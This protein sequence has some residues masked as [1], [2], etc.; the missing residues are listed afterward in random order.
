MNLGAVILCRYDSSR[1]PGK[2]L[3][4]IEGREILGYIVDR[5]RQ[6]FES[7]NIVVATSTEASDDPIAAWCER[8]GIQYYRGSKSNV[9]QRFGEA[10]E[11]RG[12]T[13]AIR[14]NGDNLFV[15]IE[16]LRS[17]SEIARRDEYDF[18]TNVKDRTFPVGMSVEIVRLSFYKKLLETFTEDRHFEHVTLYLYEH[19][20]VGNRLNVYNTEVPEAAGSKIAIDT[21]EDFVLASAILRRMEKGHLAYGMRD[22]LRFMAEVKAE[23][24]QSAENAGETS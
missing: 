1:L 22:V 11:S 13:H 5:V 2:I 24:A 9:A 4:K 16:T 19:E 8:E 21:P 23:A 6:V 17:M 14:I 15:D 10:A 20:D 3:K 7:G 18:I 12:F